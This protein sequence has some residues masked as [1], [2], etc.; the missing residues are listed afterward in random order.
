MAVIIEGGG[1]GSRAAAPVAAALVLRA[2][3]LGLLGPPGQ[4][5]GQ[6]Q[7]QPQ[8]QQQP[9]G[10]QPGGQQPNGQPQQRR[11]PRQQPSPPPRNANQRVAAARD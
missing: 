11:Q 6:P 8:Q 4:P 2:K 10:R 9:N 5:A 7:Q 3:E 1:Y